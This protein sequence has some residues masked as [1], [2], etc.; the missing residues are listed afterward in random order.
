MN[1]KFQKIETARLCRRAALGFSVMEVLILIAIMGVLG[2]IAV[3]M[4]GAQYKVASD[5]KLTSDVMAVNNLISAYVADGGNLTGLT[6]PQAILD[7]MKRSRADVD[8]KRQHT[9]A[10][11]GRLV[12]TRLKARTSTLTASNGRTRA[13]WNIRNQRF[14]LSKA[15]GTGVEEFYF[16][17]ALRNVDFGVDSTRKAGKVK[18]NGTGKG[19]VWDKAE[20]PN[21]AYS[22]IAGTSGD[23]KDNP[24]NPESE[25]PPP[26]DGGGGDTGGGSDPGSGGGDPGGGG[27]SPPTRLS[28]P[29]FVPWGSSFPYASF[30]ASITISGGV[31][32]SDGRLEYQKN[33]GG[34]VTYDGSAIPIVSGDSFAA[35]N[36]SLKPAQYI[37]SYTSSSTYYRLTQ[38]FT[39]SSTGTWGNATGGPNLLSNFE[40][41][42]ASST[43]K[44]GDTKLDLGGGEFLDAGTENV[45]KFTQ[46][47]FDTITPNTWFALGDMI[48]LNGTTFNQSEADGVTLSINLNISNPP[49]T[50]V[51][52]VNLGLISTENT[53][54]R[55]A[56][57]DIVELRNPNTDFTVTVDGV[58]YRL[59]L[60]WRTLDPGAGVVQGNQF[61][62]YE[63]SSAQAELRARFVPVF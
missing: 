29:I 27:P 21:I 7:K 43:F 33:G 2:T 36:V 28:A 31:S 19:W 37:T 55:T 13:I 34:W 60:E 16:D 35:R 23:G 38:G 22:P 14:E 54:D 61:L 50:G 18:Y 15:A 59:Q 58:T 41:G 9:G 49:Q 11:S 42:T 48:M 10:T 53:S 30:P 45:L 12:D 46:K 6:S 25:P 39:G 44:H 52:H 24:F 1:S 5:A 63:G 57:A 51:V 8:V 40:N 20:N 62:I 47:P 4:L 32:P 26:P 17:E 3:S 56:S